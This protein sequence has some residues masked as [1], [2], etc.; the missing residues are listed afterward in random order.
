MG[1]YAEVIGVDYSQVG[2]VG[3]VEMLAATVH[4]ADVTECPN[5]WETCQRVG[6]P[7]MPQQKKK[8]TENFI[9]IRKLEGVKEAK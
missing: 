7:L 4:I 2:T 8:M 3:K 5:H 9:S 1:L 6:F